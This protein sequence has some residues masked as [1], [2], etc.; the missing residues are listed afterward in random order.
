MP[1]TLHILI[2]SHPPLLEEGKG[3]ETPWYRLYCSNTVAAAA[4]RSRPPPT[5]RCPSPVDM[6]KDLLLGFRFS[7]HSISE[8][9]HT[10]VA[11]A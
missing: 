5:Y 8:T 2:F 6:T 10:H 7:Q 9:A 11:Q 3:K 4:A 1:R